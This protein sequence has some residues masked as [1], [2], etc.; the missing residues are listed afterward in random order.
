VIPKDLPAGAETVVRIFGRDFSSNA[1]VTL[2]RGTRGI[3]VLAVQ[4][5]SEEL[6]EATLRVSDDAVG[7]TIA[8]TVTNPEGPRSN[9]LELSV[10]SP[11]SFE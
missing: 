3:D 1:D 10:V 7:R 5:L 11:L 4:V 2:I 8:L 9:A 6:L